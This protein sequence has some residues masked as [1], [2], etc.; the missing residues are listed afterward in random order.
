MGKEVIF[1]LLGNIGCDV[2]RGVETG[3]YTATALVHLA[4][5]LVPSYLFK[6]ESAIES[7]KQLESGCQHSNNEVSY[8]SIAVS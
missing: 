5:L 2:A 7:G 6:M 4:V 1:S 3:G 8:F